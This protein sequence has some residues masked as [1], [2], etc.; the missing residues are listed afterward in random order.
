MGAVYT[1]APGTKKGHLLSG[2]GDGIVAQWNLETEEATGLARFEK[3]VFC[4]ANVPDRQLLVAGTQDGGLHFIDLQSK[5]PVKSIQAH[6]KS[7]FDCCVDSAGKY[8]FASA[9]DG[10]VSSWDLSSLEQKGLKKISDQSIRTITFSPDQRYLVAGASDNSIR[11]LSKDLQ[12]LKKWKAHNLSVFRLKFDRDNRLISVG[13]DAQINL[14]DYGNDMQHLHH[15]PAHMYS[16]NDLVV[17]PEKPYCFTG[18]MDKSIKIWDLR[19]MELMKVID[20]D[21]HGAHR[22]GVNRLLWLEDSLFSCGDD[23][24]VMRWQID[25]PENNSARI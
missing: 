23:K 4:L 14:W 20:Y 2:A 9:A 25:F 15:I 7:V 10:T 21:R 18:S 24:L 11:I 12:E 22:Y 1:L 13:R 5:T 17:H 16:I 6:Q 19:T 8:L 3:P